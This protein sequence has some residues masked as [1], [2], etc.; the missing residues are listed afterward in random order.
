MPW[1]LN[2]NRAPTALSSQIVEKVNSDID[3]ASYG[4]RQEGKADGQP[5]ESTNTL[6][7]AFRFRHAGILLCCVEGA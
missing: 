3:C 1:V 2:W 7:L 6:K 5:E 4:S